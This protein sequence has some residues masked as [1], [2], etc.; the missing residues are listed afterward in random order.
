MARLDDLARLDDFSPYCVPWVIECPWALQQSSYK[1]GLFGT[2][3]TQ[4]KIGEVC[5]VPLTTVDKLPRHKAHPLDT[6]VL[7]GAK[8]R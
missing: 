6:Q 8:V 1:A 2:C 3:R 4:C 7:I 5:S